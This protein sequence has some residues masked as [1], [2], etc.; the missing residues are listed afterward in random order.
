VDSELAR[1]SHL[2]LTPQ[3][4]SAWW[5]YVA[6]I[7]PF[8]LWTADFLIRYAYTKERDDAKRLTPLIR[9]F[10]N[11][12]EAFLSRDPARIPEQLRLEEL[13]L[14]SAAALGV[15]EDETGDLTNYCEQVYGLDR[16]KWPALAEALVENQLHGWK[17]WQEAD[18]PIGWVKDRTNGIHERDHTQ[19]GYVRESDALYRTPESKRAATE[20]S[21]AYDHREAA[22]DVMPLEEVAELPGVVDQ[23]L[24]PR[25]TSMAIN[26]LQAAVQEDEDL[27]AFME[28]RLQ[29]WRPRPAWEHLGWD[30]CRGRAA[31]RRFRRLREK[32]KASG[33]EHQSRE[34][35]LSPGL[36]DASCTVV[37]ERLRI[38]VKPTDEATLSGRVVYDPRVGGERFERSD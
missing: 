32:V 24:L 37:K 20:A 9:N 19:G 3:D 34:I 18:S 23:A 22:R 30:A 31:D 5:E 35:E 36:S 15:F 25:W 21:L 29:G 17:D 1:F 8:Y 33:F 4:I 26:E 10:A 16:S 6:Q 12:A 11:A 14:S 28:L 13:C 2:D 38:P 27:R 7:Q